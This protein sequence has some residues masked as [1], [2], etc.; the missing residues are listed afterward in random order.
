MFQQNVRAVQI[1]GLPGCPAQARRIAQSI[2]CGMDFG[3]EPAF[4]PAYALGFFE[5]DFA[6]DAC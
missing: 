1:A 2:A 3:A 5:E 6:P 4:G